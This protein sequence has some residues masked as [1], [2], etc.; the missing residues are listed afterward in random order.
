[1]ILMEAENLL[2]KRAEFSLIRLNTLFLSLQRND[3]GI[4]IDA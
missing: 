2:V 1:M 3:T 4:I